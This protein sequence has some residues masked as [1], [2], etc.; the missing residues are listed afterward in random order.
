MKQTQ[1]EKNKPSGTLL[2]PSEQGLNELWG[3][4]ITKYGNAWKSEY[5]EAPFK[6]GQLTILASEWSRE[7]TG[8]TKNEVTNGINQ[9]SER[10][11]KR[12]PPN[13]M[14]FKELC[15][16]NDYEIVMDQVLDRIDYGDNY[17]FTSKLAFNFWIKYAFD[18]KN[19]K[20]YDIPRLIK[21]NIKFVKNKKMYELPDY[22]LHRLKKP[23][24]K[25][26]TKIINRTKI[27]FLAVV[28]KVLLDLEINV[29]E[30]MLKVVNKKT[31]IDSDEVLSRFLKCGYVIPEKIQKEGLTDKELLL[32]NQHR[33]AMYASAVKDFINGEYRD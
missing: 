32:K 20:K 17:E 8:L 3:V 13:A 27:N 26:V 33:R 1:T 12:F 10:Q 31:L 19:G 18:L 30:K 2:A 16:G 5:F 11:E 24:E 4:M 6:N 22:E 7:L 29:P 15:V 21:Q 14:E 9:L 23:E 25:K 28:N